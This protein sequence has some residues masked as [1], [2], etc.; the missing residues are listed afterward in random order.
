MKANLT[1]YGEQVFEDIKHV[2][3]NGQEYWLARELQPVL[4]Y[5]QWR[6]LKEAIDRAK[7]ACKNSGQPVED[8]FAD[9]RKMVAIGSGASR[10][11]EDMQLSR[12]ACYLIVMNGDPRKQIIALGQ[13]YFAGKKREAD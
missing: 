13:T 5:A 1:E 7:E 3:E 8:H 6:Y 11:V 10:P 2:N 4:E 12:Y 9:V